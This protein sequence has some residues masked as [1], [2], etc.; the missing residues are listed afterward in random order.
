MSGPRKGFKPPASVTDWASDLFQDLN[1]GS[2]GDD[3][4]YQRIAN[5]PRSCVRVIQHEQ[6]MHTI[7]SGARSHEND[8]YLHFYKINNNNTSSESIRE[9]NGLIHCLDSHQ[10]FVVAGTENGSLVVADSRDCSLK[11]T[12]TLENSRVLYLNWN[13][14]KINIAAVNGISQVDSETLSQISLFP[15]DFDIEFPVFHS[16]NENTAFY[17]VDGVT[18]LNSAHLFDYRQNTNVLDFHHRLDVKNV[19]MIQERNDCLLLDS[20]RL[21]RYDLRNTA[22]PVAVPLKLNPQT[23]AWNF[24]LYRDFSGRGAC[25]AKGILHIFDDNTSEMVTMTRLPHYLEPKDI[26][27]NESG[28]LLAVALSSPYQKK[29]EEVG[30]VYFRSTFRGIDFPDPYNVPA[31]SKKQ[32]CQLQ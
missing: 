5:F 30:T 9:N 11:A 7:V 17:S 3:S 25:A 26:H 28:T 15:Q 31:K 8:S 12:K 20:S 18:P 14:Q 21:Y 23:E 19:N 29:A 6:E 2:V 1:P 22:E 4:C 24:G 10:E 27:W 13:N 16:D 32:Q